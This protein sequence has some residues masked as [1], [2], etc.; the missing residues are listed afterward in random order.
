[1]KSKPHWPAGLILA[2]ILVVL[3]PRF[4][5]LQ[6]AMLTV[7]NLGDNDDSVCNAVHCTLREAINAANTNP[8]PDTITFSVTGVISTTGL[9]ILT[10]DGTVI[11]ASEVFGLGPLGIG[12]PGIELNGPPIDDS[13]GFLIRGASDVRISGFFITGFGDGIRLELGA[14][15]NI[16]GTNADGTRD[17][18]E[19]NVI[20]GVTGDGDCGVPNG[21][22]GIEIN[23][24]TTSGNIVAGNFIG[25]DKLGIAAFGNGGRGIYINNTPNNIIGGSTPATRNIISGNEA[26]GIRIDGNAARGNIISGNYIGTD[27]TGSFNLGNGAPGI[28]VLAPG[29]IIGG[30]A[31]GEGNVISGNS[32]SGLSISS[33]G[34]NT[35]VLGNFIGTDATGTASIGNVLM[36]IFI[37]NTRNVM[38]GGTVAG[39]RNII[40]GNVDEGVEIFISDEVTILGNYIGTDV[41]GAAR[42]SNGTGVFV[43]FSPNTVIGGVN[44]AARNVISGNNSGI[45]IQG[46][47]TVVQGNYIGLDVTGTTLL[48]NSDN[49]VT[50][51]QTFTFGNLIG[52]TTIGA[53][54]LIGGNGGHGVMMGIDAE[55][56]LLFGNYIGTDVSGIANLGNG[57]DGVHIEYFEEAGANAI[58]GTA[59]G[60]ANTIAFN[61]GAGVSVQDS[62]GNSILGN[63]IYD[64]AGLG[65]DL[66]AD[67]VT[68][69]DVGD[70]DTGANNRQNFPML[71]STISTAF[72]TT[73]TGTLHSTPTTTLDLEF[74]SNSSCD[75]SDHGEGKKFL[76]SS[77]VTT[78]GSGNVDFVVTFPTGV[79]S[80][81]FSMTATATDPGHNTSEFSSCV[82]IYKGVSEPP[83]NT[84]YAKVV[85]KD[86]LPVTGVQLYWNG[87][88]LLDPVSGDPGRT[89]ILGNILLEG[90]GIQSGHTLVA[91]AQQAEQSTA[92]A[93]HDGWAYRTYLT[94]IDVDAQGTPQAFTVTQL[95][96]RQLLTVHPENTLVLFNIVVSVEWDAADAYLAEVASAVQEASDYLYDLTDGQMAFGQVS[97]YDNGQFWA[98]A[99]IQISTKNIVHPHAYIG[100]ITSN[101]KSHVIRIGR[102]W[103]GN[104][105][106]EGSWAQPAGFRTLAHEF[107]HY[108]LYLY[109]EYFAYTFDQNGNLT[110]EVPAIC[111]GP[112]NRNPA[113]DASNASAMDYQYTTTELSARG[114]PGMWSSLCE[115][116]AQWQFNG[117]STWETLSRKYA[118]TNSPA[119]WR[120]TTPADRGAVMAGPIGLPS[121]VL[122]LPAVTINNSGASGPP[123]P[124]TVEYPEGQGYWGALVAL[125]KQDG[126]VVGQ[127]FTDGNGQLDVYGAEEGDT[128]RAA[129]FDAG[130]AGSVTVGPGPNL[131]LTLAPITG[132]AIQAAGGTPYVRVIADP[133]QNPDQVD[134]LISLYNFGPGADP[135]VIVTEPGSEAGYA[136]TLGYSPGTDTYEGQISFSATERGM[137]RIQAVGAVGNSLVRLQ[138]TYRLQ[139]VL[140]SQSYDVYSDDGN[141]SLHLEPDS[142]PGSEAYFVVM[143]PGAVPG[144]P[145]AGLWL[146]GDPYDITASGALVVLE[147]P[148]LLTLHY[149]GALVTSS[150]APAG[151]G[152]YRWDPNG[153]LW[154][155]KPG[156]LDETQKAVVAP[157][158]TLGTYALLAP[159]GSW[160]K[161]APDTIFL[162]FILKAAPH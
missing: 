72:N 54:N 121:D 134:L 8:G 25:T 22:D 142:L 158:A 24:G 42:L 31:S 60:E 130:L 6:A 101:D 38:V 149:D 71:I 37:D 116:T 96:E 76:D 156:T 57:Q 55:N 97:I 95:G 59:P 75:P 64:N 160:N 49:G 14:S 152:I 53:G 80:N 41:S 33:G 108:A 131:T 56:N 10:G 94:N 16:I 11:D 98:D 48:G 35:V 150:V 105:G 85:D 157:V 58:G 51:W 46:N 20:S 162:P 138:S 125:Y 63:A 86:G 91:L 132:L 141:L 77:Q 140:D 68:P 139:R 18:K 43:S 19:R 27:V 119:R 127:G 52:G 109:D 36:G 128:L 32:T 106:N 146:V 73:I 144:P 2:G 40:S 112:E 23:G 21:C 83:P 88:L 45:E 7:N 110:G 118:D 117:E 93:G 39:A 84:T 120:L 3:S 90:L 15:N 4:S 47:R 135:S 13:V 30:T 115:Q 92:R 61:G 66:D 28:Y 89:D 148:G 82:P 79:P 153:E 133:S 136:P 69:N 5:S 147:Q 126:R 50:L 114:V 122:S 26:N 99:D 74:F 12:A 81:H 111:T 161:P 104:S 123:R 65:I 87:N 154:Q 124:L 67:G 100:G 102:G 113:T 159:A 62:T 17:T 78:D 145:P 107:G 143:P 129:S 137:G 29:N 103:N 151:L 9:P 70:S 1:M 155:A 44:E 34:E